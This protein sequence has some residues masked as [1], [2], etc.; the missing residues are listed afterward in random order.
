MALPL[1]EWTDLPLDAI[2][3]IVA[4]KLR[5]V[6]LQRAEDQLPCELSGGMRKR[7]AIARAMALEPDL[8]FLDEPSAGLD[9]VTG[10]RARRADPRA[11]R[12]SSA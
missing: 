3:A 2:G 1:Q 7:A 12:S 4:A 5:L 10:G 8:L 9:P 6:G 11:E